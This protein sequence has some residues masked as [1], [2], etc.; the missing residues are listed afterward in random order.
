VTADD[1]QFQTSTQTAH[2][3]PSAPVNKHFTSLT[4][5]AAITTS[6]V[7]KTSTEEQTEVK[8]T[9]HSTELHLLTDTSRSTEILTYLLM[10]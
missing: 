6:E 7:G 10:C 8:R 9:I 1:P 3:R 4:T 5:I 2:S